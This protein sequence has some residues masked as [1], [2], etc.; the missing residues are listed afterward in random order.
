MDYITLTE[1]YFFE[2]DSLFWFLLV[3]STVS[4]LVSAIMMVVEIITDRIST[5]E[6]RSIFI[7]KLDNTEV[8]INDLSKK[9]I[10]AHDRITELQKLVSELTSKNIKLNHEL[11]NLIK[12]LS[13]EKK[14]L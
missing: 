10:F 14:H 12:T 4:V 3:V 6:V 5:T 1:D 13:D 8:F 9:V 2:S 11:N 7:K